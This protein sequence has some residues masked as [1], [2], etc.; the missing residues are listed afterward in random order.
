MYFIIIYFIIVVIQKAVDFIMGIF[1]KMYY[2]V[3]I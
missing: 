2:F 1:R 3:R